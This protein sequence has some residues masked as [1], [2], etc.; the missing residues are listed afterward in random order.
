MPAGLFCSVS[1]VGLPR[2]CLPRCT[3]LNLSRGPS[4][5]R[6]PV[7]SSSLNFFCLEPPNATCPLRVNHPPV[8]C[9]C[10]LLLTLAVHLPLGSCLLLFRCLAGQK[11]MV[12]E[13]VGLWWQEGQ[14]SSPRPG[15]DARQTR[16]WRLQV[17]AASWLP[18]RSARGLG[19][20]HFLSLLGNFCTSQCPKAGTDPGGAGR[21]GTAGSCGALQLVPG[22][23]HG[24]PGFPTVEIP[25]QVPSACHLAHSLP[26]ILGPRARGWTPSATSFVPLGPPLQVEPT[27]PGWWRLNEHMREG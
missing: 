22:L 8:W 13:L 18:V 9:P 15:T 10:S 12:Q 3:G 23:V 11:G 16:C 24:L 1:K 21:G 6:I 27:S 2:A 14:P 4:F 25:R 5:P 19:T 7:D 17:A 20:R 26:Y